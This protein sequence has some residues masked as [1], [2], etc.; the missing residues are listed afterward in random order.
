ME[1]NNFIKNIKVEDKS[2]IFA[3]Q[4]RL[5]N[6]EIEI[7]DLTDEQL[8]AMIELYEGRIEKKKNKLK[9]YRNIIMKN[10]K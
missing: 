7:S 3:L 6:K 8:Q 4:K 5:E 1:N 2:W 10:K 9:E